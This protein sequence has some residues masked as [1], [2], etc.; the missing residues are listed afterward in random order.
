MGDGGYRDKV[1]SSRSETD[2]MKRDNRGGPLVSRKFW[3]VGRY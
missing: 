3:N 2:V 1:T